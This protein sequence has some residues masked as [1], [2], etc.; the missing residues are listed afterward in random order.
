MPDTDPNMI[1]DISG[2]TAELASD[3]NTSGV[4]LTGA[5]VQIMKLGFGD[6]TVTTRVSSSDPFPVILSGQTGDVSITGSLNGTGEFEI[7]NL[8]HHGASAFYL[9]VAGSTSGALVGMTGTV[10]GISNGF[11]VGVSGSVWVTNTASIQGVYSGTSAEAEWDSGASGGFGIP[12]A[13]TGGRRLNSATDSIT[14]SGTVNATGGKNLGAATDAVS[15]YGW[16]ADRYVATKL[17]SDDGTTAGFSGD[18]LKVAI[19]NTSASVTFNVSATTGVT[20]DVETS[21]GVA[22]ALKV[23][24]ITGGEPIIVKGEN[25]GAVEI[26]S[27]SALN[28]T[29]SGTVTIDDDDIVASLENETKPLI[30]NLT[31]IDSNTSSIAGIR[32]DMLGGKIRAKITEMVRPSKIHSGNNT[33]TYSAS[34]L[35]SNSQLLSG[36]NVKS[37]PYNTTNILV[38]SSDLINNTTQGYLLEPGESMFIE[39]DNLNKVYARIASSGTSG[40]GNQSIYYLGS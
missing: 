4:G 5:H 20:N 7:T 35:S 9:A 16:D 8:G 14:V 15:V 24:G 23:Q 3:Y 21:G 10:Q 30:S 6:E 2:N 33:V 29:I 27:T 28:T 19:T 37:S 39:C 11:P 12:V 34:N 26:V 22:G 25:G 13:I 32:T 31:S 36:V 1:I 18:A 38:G 40:A 17:F